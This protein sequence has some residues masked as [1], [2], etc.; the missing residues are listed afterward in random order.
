MN[1]NN[2]NPG[3]QPPT[4]EEMLAQL[5]HRLEALGVDTNTRIEA[6]TTSVN[7]RLNQIEANANNL[8][9]RTQAL[10]NPHEAAA[11]QPP[12]LPPQY[13]EVTGPALARRP[14]HQLPH[15]AAYDNTDQSLF[16]PFLAELQAK[17]AIDGTAIGNNFARVWYVFNRLAGDARTKVYPWLR[18][19]AQDPATA[20]PDV[21]ERF[22]HH[23][24]VLF[25]NRQLVEQSN[26]ELNRLRQGRTPFPEFAAEFERLLLL[27]GGQA[28]NDEVRIA[29]LRSAINQEMRQAIIGQLL[30]TTYSAFLEHLH[31]VANDLN[32][33]NRIRNLRTSTNNRGLNRAPFGAQRPTPT[34]PPGPTPIAAPV[35]APLAYPVPMDISSATAPA[36]RPP[37]TPI[38]CYNCGGS[39]H[40]ARNCPQPPR[41]RQPRRVAFNNTIPEG[42][43]DAT[44]PQ[45]RDP[46]VGESDSENE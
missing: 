19:Y 38:N 6:L 4:I 28:W 34:N 36:T 13:E 16:L 30:P 15:P 39:G 46:T 14:R 27:A 41:P 20:A 33:Y 45:E 8:N 7:D 1:P 31:R 12:V 22:Y 35:A 23:L 2:P 9:Q 10:E 40:I 5:M 17:F 43:S 3:E 29:R 32:E 44:P 11:A 26:Q 24:N 21:L 18:I 25:E 42:P 37:V